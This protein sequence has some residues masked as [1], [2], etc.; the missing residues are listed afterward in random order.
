MA[1]GVGFVADIEVA[2]PPRLPIWPILEKEPGIA[3]RRWDGIR[4]EQE[5]EEEK[6]GKEEE[7]K[8]S[9]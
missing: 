3:K 8:Q 2:F 5:R 9:G 7:D 6:N 4:M 1:F